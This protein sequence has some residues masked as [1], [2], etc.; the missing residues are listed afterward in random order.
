METI[1][2]MRRF[3]RA[4]TTVGAGHHRDQEHSGEWDIRD[5]DR[6]GVH[7]VLNIFRY[8]LCD[9]F[10]GGAGGDAE[11]LVQVAEHEQ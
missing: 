1:Q 6:R 7:E 11:R 5:R 3:P 8:Q 4:G 10:R 2:E 9:C